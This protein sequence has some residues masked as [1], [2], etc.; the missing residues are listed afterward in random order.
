MGET[1]WCFDPGDPMLQTCMDAGVPAP[2]PSGDAA[3]RPPDCP[4]VRY[5][6]RTVVGCCEDAAMLVAGPRSKYVE[7]GG[8]CCY[9]A[10]PGVHER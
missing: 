7:S 3:P 9:L 5:L 2:S 1:E 6:C 8:R 4:N 10:M